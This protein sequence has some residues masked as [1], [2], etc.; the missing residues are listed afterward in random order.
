MLMVTWF[1]NTSKRALTYNKSDRLNTAHFFENKF[2]NIIKRN[3]KNLVSEIKKTIHSI[4]LESVYNFLVF[5]NSK[6]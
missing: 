5:F 1:R 2:V 6:L 4:D 3:K